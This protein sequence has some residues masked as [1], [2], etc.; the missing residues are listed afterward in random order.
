MK[1]D[2]AQLEGSFPLDPWPLPDGYDPM[3]TPSHCRQIDCWQVRPFAQTAPTPG[4]AHVYMLLEPDMR[5]TA[6][7]RVNTG[8][9]P[10]DE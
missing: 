1:D 6:V 3:A 7:R 4:A 2:S 10:C 9:L 5:V 8:E